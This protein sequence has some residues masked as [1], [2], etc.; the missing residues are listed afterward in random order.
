VAT[1]RLKSK[2]GPFHITRRGFVPSGGYEK[3]TYDFPLDNDCR[4][5]MPEEV[6]G[7]LRDEY[8]DRAMG[9]RYKDAVM[10]L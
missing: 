9:M 7:S 5:E 1:V 2:V 4:C 3:V 10:E 8:L 6:W